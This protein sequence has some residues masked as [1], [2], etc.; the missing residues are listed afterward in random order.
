MP[1]TTL[2]DLEQ[3]LSELS[4]SDA[5]I[6]EVRSFSEQLGNTQ[7]RINV[8]NADNAMVR[9]PITPEQT[10]ALGFRSVEDDFT[11]VQGDIVSTESA[12]FLGERIA[13]RPKYVVL[14]SSCDLVPNRREFGSLLRVKP[15]TKMEERAKEKLNLLLRFKK[16]ASMY[17]P[18]FPSDAA[19]VWCNAIDFDG[20]CQIRSE[21]LL[22]A[23][24]IASLTLVGWRIFASFSRTVVARANP[25]EC[26]MRIAIERPPASTTP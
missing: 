16:S 5:A 18:P 20:I 11:L 17:L 25:R 3:K 15:I 19:D 7:A 21:S 2:Y 14:N 9:A 24:R 10:R 4:H 12:Y 13:S 22:L 23:S 1:I 6:V 26:E 8:L